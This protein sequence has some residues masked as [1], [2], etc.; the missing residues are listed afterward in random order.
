M[1]IEQLLTYRDRLLLSR[2]AT[3]DAAG[4]QASILDGANIHL[5]LD[6]TG[7]TALHL[8]ADQGHTDACVALVLAG[9]DVNRQN[10][11][12][13]SLGSFA[14]AWRYDKLMLLSVAVKVDWGRALLKGE[15]STPK[16]QR[17][18]SL[19]PTQAAT[20]LKNVDVLSFVLAGGRRA[21]SAPPIRTAQSPCEGWP[22][23]SSN[24]AL[25]QAAA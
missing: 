17:I 16:M 18:M 11:M 21:Q 19:S 22:V 4:V 6:K 3:G 7:D 5:R 1:I 24:Q 13:M 12:G 9:A 14:H 25:L 23:Q 10:R 8:A 20:R 15:I 2:A